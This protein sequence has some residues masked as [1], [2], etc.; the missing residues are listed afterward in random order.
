MRTLTADQAARQVGVSLRL[1]Y[2][3]VEQ[4]KL[5]PVRITTTDRMRFIEHEVVEVAAAE[6]SGRRRT[7]LERLTRRWER[8][9]AS[10]QRG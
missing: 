5:R 9:C 7:R 10:V 3:W 8:E 2:R 6:R 4:G 1:V